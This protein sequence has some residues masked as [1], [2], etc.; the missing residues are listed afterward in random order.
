MKAMQECTV[1]LY[2]TT[3]KRQALLFGL[4]EHKGFSIGLIRMTVT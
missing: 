4:V 1:L 3:T 2:S